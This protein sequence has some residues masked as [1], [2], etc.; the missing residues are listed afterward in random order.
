M[1][2]SRSLSQ[3]LYVGRVEPHCRVPLKT[4]P[5][6]RCAVGR[7]LY[8]EVSKTIC[9]VQDYVHAGGGV[10]TATTEDLFLEVATASL[11]NVGFSLVLQQE[12]VTIRYVTGEPQPHGARQ[13]LSMAVMCAAYVLMG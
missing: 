10:A 9:P 12:R 4:H 5:S 6:N 11:A 7:H 8:M 13:P 3:S 2:A 1:S